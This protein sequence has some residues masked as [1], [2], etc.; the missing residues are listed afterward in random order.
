MIVR[1]HQERL[2][3]GQD[4]HLRSSLSVWSGGP[5]MYVQLEVA[6]QPSMQSIQVMVET[7]V[8]QLQNPCQPPETV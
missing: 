6:M 8:Q 4:V 7:F 3:L 1:T 5:C 2:D